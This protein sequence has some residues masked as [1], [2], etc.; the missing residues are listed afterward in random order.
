MPVPTSDLQSISP[1]A[2]IELFELQLV[3]ALHGSADVYRFHAGSSLNANGAIIWNSNTYTRYPVEADGFEYTGNGQLPQPRLRVANIL[4]TI[5]SL[6]LSVNAVTPGN[7][8]IGAKVT[9]IR[10]LARYIDA[11]NFPARRNLFLRSDE[12]DSATWTKVRAAVTANTAQGPFGETT[13]DLLRDD[14]TASSTHY[15]EQTVSGLTSGTQYS[16]S[17]YARP[18]GRNFL[19]LEL[20]SGGAFTATQAAVFDLSSGKVSSTVGTAAAAVA[21]TGNGWVRCSITATTGAAGS[22]AAR[23]YLQSTAGSTSYTGN[24]ASGVLLSDAQIEAGGVTS[25]QDIGASFSQNPLGTPDPTVEFPREIYYVSQK[26]LEN[27]DVVEFTLSAA[28]DMQ[29]VRAPKRQCIGNICQ[30]TYR[31]AEC[32]YTGTG[33]YDENDS[34]VGSAALDVCGKRVSS[35]QLRFAF[36]SNLPTSG[37]TNTL[38]AGNTLAAGAKLVSSNGW[39]QLIMQN[40]GNLV[41]YDK[42]GNARW[43]SKTPIGAAARLIMQ[44]DGNAVVYRNSNNAVLWSSGTANSGGNRITMQND[45]NLVIYTAANAAVWASASNGGASSDLEPHNTDIVLPF[46]SFPGVGTYFA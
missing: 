2:I 37:T 4:G 14:T 19:R 6:L 40:D 10:T 35:C 38:S 7:D 24:G 42:A 21:E 46:G 11:A 32:G 25:Y 29:G 26:S 20:P 39:Y 22:V 17:V 9:R 45:G 44:N 43:S 30:W 28:F 1:S 23:V 15:A 41:I 12:F 8:L 31:S 27:R 5:T 36:I 16:F 18:S 34:P 13:A 3:T 33:Y